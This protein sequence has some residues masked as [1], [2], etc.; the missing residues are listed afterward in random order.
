MPIIYKLAY[1][2][3]QLA[4]SIIHTVSLNI[5]PRISELQMFHDIKIP[6]SPYLFIYSKRVECKSY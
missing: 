6:E 5:F 1:C 3:I 2:V 4:F